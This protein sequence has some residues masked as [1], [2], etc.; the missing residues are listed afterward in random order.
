MPSGSPRNRRLSALFWLGLILFNYP[1][2]SLFDVP[3]T[4]LGIPLLYAY[5]FGVWLL[6]I[7]FLAL[8]ARCRPTLPLPDA[9]RQTDQ[10]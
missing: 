4:L 9:P 8:T 1:L 2:L 3:K 5:L 6:L 10:C 7:L